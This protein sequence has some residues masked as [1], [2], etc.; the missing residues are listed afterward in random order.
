VGHP[1]HHLCINR[2]QEPRQEGEAEVTV[3][4]HRADEKEIAFI[5]SDQIMKY[6]HQCNWRQEDTDATV[7]KLA[8]GSMMTL[9]L[10][11]RLSVDSVPT[12]SGMRSRNRVNEPRSQIVRL[13]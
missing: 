7:Q 8:S 3:N 10:K 6:G 1:I 5:G 12:I 2:L 11:W 13:S 4:Q 9:P